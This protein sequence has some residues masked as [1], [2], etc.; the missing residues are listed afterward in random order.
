MNNQKTNSYGKL[1]VFFLVAV[2]LILSF[3]FVADGWQPNTSKN[4]NSGNTDGSNGFFQNGEV[5]NNKF[6]DGNTT[7]PEHVSPITGLETDELL[8]ARAP[9]AISMST[10]SA[11]YGIS[12]ADMLIEFPIE[13]GDTR[14]LLISSNYEELGKIGS[15]SPTRAY[16]STIS[17]AFGAILVS[18][19]ED[20]RKSYPSAAASALRFD[21][22]LIPGYHYTEYNQF[23][24]TN[25]D[26][27][28]CGISNSG[29]LQAEITTALPY[30]FAAF[31]EETSGDISATSVS[32][33]YSQGKETEL[34]YSQADGTYTVAKSGTAL[35]DMLNDKTPKFKNAFILFADTTT[36]ET[37]DGTHLVM[38]SLGS[39]A[40]YYVTLGTAT[41]ITWTVAE[42]GQMNMYDASG[43]VL[44][45][46]R[47]TTYVG[48][49]K[50]SYINEN[51][52]K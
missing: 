39:G 50:S 41:P 13:N 27:L 22:S 21:L 10:S 40:G 48:F 32:L 26:L 31:G 8:S 4:E 3:G 11:L 24:Y 9:L 19:G 46:N 42:N 33:P 43:K 18:D 49:F 23:A 1:L 25:G 7:I 14:F 2:I 28:Y 29:L 36:Y 51:L 5:D 17:K 52:I 38:N 12:A 15:I 47:G 34:I 16:I 35:H 20:D 30:S 44:T 6:Q 37:Q 45:V